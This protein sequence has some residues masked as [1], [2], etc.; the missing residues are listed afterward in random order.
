[1]E[2]VWTGRTCVYGYVGEVSRL[3]CCCIRLW[4]GMEGRKDDKWEEGRE[5]EGG[6]KAT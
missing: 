5:G 4:R 1:M 2:V 3:G 6:E